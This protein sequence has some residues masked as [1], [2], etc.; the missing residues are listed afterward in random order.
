MCVGYNCFSFTEFYRTLA[1]MQLTR[2]IEDERIHMFSTCRERQTERILT[3]QLD[4]ERLARNEA[5]EAERLARNEALAAERLVGK[6]YKKE[7]LEQIKK[8]NDNNDRVLEVQAAHAVLQSEELGQPKRIVIAERYELKGTRGDVDGMVVGMHKGKNVVVFIEAKTNMDSCFKKCK[9]QLVLLK[10]YWQDLCDQSDEI[11]DA[12]ICDKDKLKV[13][14]YATYIPMF[15]FAGKKFSAEMQA[16]ASK[17]E[18]PTICVVPID[19]GGFKAV[20]P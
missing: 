12:L 19:A 14:D 17:L 16:K 4:A 5:L 6:S 10:N 7:E 13:D 3:L 2:L 9:E 15:A 8:Y 11:T 18:T 1:D 20:F